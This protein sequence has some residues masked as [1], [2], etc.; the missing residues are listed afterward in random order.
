V[1]FLAHRSALA[2]LI[3][4]LIAIGGCLP[5]QRLLAGENSKKSCCNS[6]GECQRP[7]PDT[8]TK[9]ACNLQV[10]DAKS[11]PQQ[12]SDRLIDDDLPFSGEIMTTISPV[13][14]AGPADASTV[15]F[16]ASPPPLF[17]LN[18]SLLI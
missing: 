17:L 5:C 2:V 14:T 6:K 1:I 9:K 8:P 11:E 3:A 18:L 15:G 4:A 16:D 12:Q 13:H 10:A 7:R